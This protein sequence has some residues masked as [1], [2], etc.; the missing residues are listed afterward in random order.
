MSTF[1]DKLL[2]GLPAVTCKMG[3]ACKIHKKWPTSIALVNLP[4]FHGRGFTE[5][6]V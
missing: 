4:N 2:K 3:D 6:Y 5:V 1:G